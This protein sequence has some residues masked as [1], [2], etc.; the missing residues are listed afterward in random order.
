MEYKQWNAKIEN[1]TS[2]ASCTNNK[3]NSDRTES[4]SS[5]FFLS[6][7]E[8]I[9]RRPQ[10]F[11]SPA[12][13]YRSLSRD[14]TVVPL[15]CRWVSQSIPLWSDLN[16]GINSVQMSEWKKCK[17]NPWQQSKVRRVWHLND[18]LRKLNDLIQN[19]IKYCKTLNRKNLCTYL[20]TLEILIYFN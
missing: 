17:K 12:F 5:T 14:F 8:I 2:G 13:S 1:F 7:P 3:F 18:C 15:P 9:L 19:D 11:S 4:S 20:R 16:T 10:C 6:I